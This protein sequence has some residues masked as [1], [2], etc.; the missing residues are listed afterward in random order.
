MLQLIFPTKMRR[1]YLLIKVQMAKCIREQGSKHDAE[2]SPRTI[3]LHYSHGTGMKMFQTSDRSGEG[4]AQTQHRPQDQQQ[5]IL[6]EGRKTCL[7]DPDSD[8]PESILAYRL[9]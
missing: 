5:L 7:D 1:W 3:I 9:R 4:R 6:R 2:V 8:F